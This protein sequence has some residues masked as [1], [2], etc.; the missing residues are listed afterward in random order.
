MP[1]L[2]STPAALRESIDVEIGIMCDPDAGREARIARERLVAI[3]KPAFPRVL[4]KA[5]GLRDGLLDK[6]EL[7]IDEQILQNH[8][9][10]SIA[11]CDRALR[12]MDGYLTSKNVMEIKPGHGRRYVR[13]I[14]GHHYKRW[15]RKLSKM[16]TMPGP[17]SSR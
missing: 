12:E 14:L 5:A 1:H 2:D 13:Y 10:A 6:K 15:V 3:G 11:L 16:D 17:A 7:T 8:V 4:G 9:I